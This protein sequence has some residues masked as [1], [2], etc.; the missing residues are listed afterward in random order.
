MRLVTSFSRPT[1]FS[2]HARD[3]ANP[4]TFHA[5]DAS[6]QTHWRSVLP[7]ARPARV[8]LR[9]VWECVWRCLPILKPGGDGE[10]ANLSGNG[11]FQCAAIA[12][13]SPARQESGNGHAPLVSTQS[14]PVR[15]VRSFDML[16]PVVAMYAYSAYARIQ[17]V[18]SRDAFGDSIAAFHTQFAFAER[19]L[20]ASTIRDNAFRP[21]SLLL[22][23]LRCFLLG[24]VTTG[25]SCIKQCPA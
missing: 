16:S 25:S 10:L 13:C 11:A 20:H 22:L 8:D 7:A 23:V 18:T 21:W 2:L 3:S 4:T 14:E 17:E 1:R 12:G 15:P 24:P 6:R 19:R 5:R 9:P